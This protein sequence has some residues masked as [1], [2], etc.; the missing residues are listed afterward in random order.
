DSSYTGIHHIDTFK[1]VAQ[2]LIDLTK[3]EIKYG[4]KDAF[5]QWRN[6]AGAFKAQFLGEFKA[7]A[8]HQYPFNLPVDEK[9]GVLKGWQALLGSDATVILPVSIK[10]YLVRVNSMPE[11]CTVST[12]TWLMPTLHSQLSVPAMTAITQIQQYYKTEEN[13]CLHATSK[14]SLKFFDI[15]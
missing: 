2:F 8:R 3:K 9:K 14:P 7:Y 1:I 5:I 13:A 15:K 10:I 12:F 4:A 11:E 6:R